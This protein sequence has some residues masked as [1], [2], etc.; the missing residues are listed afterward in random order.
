MNR[1]IHAMSIALAL[2]V[3]PVILAEDAEVID[4]RREVMRTLGEQVQALS[5]TARGKAP[6]ANFS[7][8][9]QALALASRQAL[10]AFEPRAEGGNAKP[11]VW[12]NWT[13]FSAKLNQLVVNLTELDKAGKSGGAAAGTARMK[14]LLTCQG[15]HDTYR[16]PLS[17]DSTKPEA[18]AAIQYRRHMMSSIDAQSTALGQILSMEIPDANLASHLEVLA[19]VAGGSLKAFEPKVPGGESKAEVWSHWPDFSKRMDEFAHKTAQ[20]AT[21][22]REQGNDAALP[23]IVE[24]LT[25]KGCHDIYRLKK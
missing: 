5:M 25:C 3:A 10:K 9:T 20:A 19:V 15:C 1:W 22:A 8:H 13:D 11:D 17:P 14:E 23:G 16:K 4:Y 6:A 7:V 12:K 21:V 18:N 2:A 24:A